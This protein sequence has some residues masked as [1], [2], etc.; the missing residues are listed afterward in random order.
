MSGTEEISDIEC[1]IC[2]ETDRSFKPCRCG[3]QICRVCWNDINEK[4][5]GRCPACRQS[6]KSGPENYKINHTEEVVRLQ[7]K[8]L[9]EQKKIQVDSNAR[10]QLANVRVIQRNLVYITNLALSAAKEE[11]LRKNEYF[12][13]F[14]K[15]IKTIVN[16]NNIYSGPQGPSVSAYVTY[17]LNRDAHSAIKAT[18]GTIKDGRLLRASFGTTKYCSYFLRNTR[19]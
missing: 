3:Y 9:K 17:L 18:D 4:Q 7:P 15:I 11:T 16:R 8:K 10:K 6:Y 12:G 2:L 14:G 1:P 13:K 5:N 19:S